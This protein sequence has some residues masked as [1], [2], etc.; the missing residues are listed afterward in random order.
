MRFLLSLLWH[1][2]LYVMS[3]K[4]LK[5]GD[6]GQSKYMATHALVFMVRD[7]SSKWKQPVGYFLISGPITGSHSLGHV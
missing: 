1:I 7:L 5:T 3:L 2:I 6:L 4:V